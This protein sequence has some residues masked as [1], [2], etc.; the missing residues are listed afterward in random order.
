MAQKDG[1]SFTHF[2]VAAD[3]QGKPFV[4]G[5]FPNLKSAKRAQLPNTWVVDQNGKVLVKT[6]E[7]FKAA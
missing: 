2:L 5:F 3:E 4:W 6:Y 7:G 1:Y